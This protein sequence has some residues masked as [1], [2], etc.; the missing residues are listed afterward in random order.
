MN[1]ELSQRLAGRRVVASISGGKDSAALSLWL[2]EQGIDHDRVHMLTGWD[3]DVT[4][5][6]IRGPLTTALGQI[7]EIRGDLLLPDLARKKGMFPSKQRRYCTDLLKM[8]PLARYLAALE[9]DAVS[10]VGIR[11]GE[12]AARAALTEWEWS[13]GLDCEVWR[14]LLA[15]SVEDVIEIHRRH[16]LAPNPL[17]LRGAERVGCW[18]CIM[19]RKSEIKLIA[20]TDP[21]S[22]DELRALE[23][24]VTARG[25][26]IVEARGETLTSQRTFFQAAIGGEGVWPIDR[27]VAWSRTKRGGRIEDKQVELFANDNPGCRRWGLCETDTGAE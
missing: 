3:A 4:M 10:A 25:R 14:P 23:A 2:T 19:A 13:D 27:V 20:D 1:P 12:S 21:K 11:G 17:Y 16:G 8:Q 24:E 6:Y 15:W 5:N 9:E 7:V 26:E 18:P 22:I